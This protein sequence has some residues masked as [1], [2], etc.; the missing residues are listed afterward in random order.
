VPYY[1]MS[2]RS[3]FDAFFATQSRVIRVSTQS[4]V[5]FCCFF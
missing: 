5:F 1:S 2:G 4:L 3:C